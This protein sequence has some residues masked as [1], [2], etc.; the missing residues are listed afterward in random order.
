VMWGE[1]GM[2]S[3]ELQLLGS[4]LVSSMRFLFSMLKF[5]T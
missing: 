3:A 5:T 1:A 4:R 2:R